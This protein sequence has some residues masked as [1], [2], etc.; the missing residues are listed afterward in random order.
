M[1]LSFT[2]KNTP[3]SLLISSLAPL[4]FQKD[5]ILDAFKIQGILVSLLQD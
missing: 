2:T 3:L 5:E 4:C 1:V